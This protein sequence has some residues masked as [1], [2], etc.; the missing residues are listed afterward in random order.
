MRRLIKVLSRF[1]HSGRIARLIV[2]ICLL[3][4][5]LTIPA[6]ADMGPKPTVSVSFVYDHELWEKNHLT[7]YYVTLL[8]E[9]TGTGPYDVNNHWEGSGIPEIIWNAFSDYKDPDGY[10]F[11]GYVEECTATDRFTWGY[12]PPKRFKVLAY[13]PEAD[14]YMSSLE[15][16]ARYA[17]D[18]YFVDR[19]D[20]GGEPHFVLEQNYGFGL[21]A[22]GFLFRLALT[23]LIEML[24]ALAFGY[25]SKK[26]LLIILAVNTVTQIILNGLLM[27]NGFQPGILYVI[28]YGGFELLVFLIEAVIYC[29]ALDRAAE[30][31]P[32][33]VR[34]CVY[35]AAANLLSF[36]VGYMISNHL[37]Y[38]F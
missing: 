18:S 3:C 37:R 16:V 38:L 36:W 15:P 10:H 25:R 26:Q 19:E 9:E 17:F 2:L 1:Q 29:L 32:N 6:M 14:A 20:L 27:A 12:M 22:A 7:T 31:K 23:I 4:V 34:A 11:L 28:T 21:Q 13:F 33:A 8:A 35:A 30:K 5:A 24:V